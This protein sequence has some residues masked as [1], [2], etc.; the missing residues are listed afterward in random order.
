MIKENL[1]YASA[2]ITDIHFKVVSSSNG[3][4]RIILNHREQEYNH[5]EITRL[6][7][8]DPYM[9]G[10]FQQISE[11]LNLDRKTFTIPL[12]IHG[13]DFQLKVWDE[14]KKIPYGKTIS[15]KTLA[16]R[17]MNPGSV[18]AVGGANASN[19]VPVII[20]C[21]RVIGNKGTLTGYS[22]GLEVKER[23]LE[24]EGGISLE[25]FNIL[26]V[27]HIELIEDY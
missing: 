7:P 6:H 13:T 12:D 21:H 17:I 23:L 22:G 19:P 4:R 18:R 2:T 11:Y 5:P 15:Y 9:F 10:V 8:E 25:L 27:N 3:I 16:R 14:V 20:P 1:F 24:L 26:R